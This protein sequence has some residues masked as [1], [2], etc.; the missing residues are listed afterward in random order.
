M[1][2]DAALRYLPIADAI[3][4]NKIKEPILEVG[5]GTNGISDYYDGYV[6]GVD[7]DFSKTNTCKN[8][9]I[10]HKKGTIFKIPFKKESFLKVVCL[11]TLEHINKENR[12]NALNELLRVTKKDGTLYL[13]FPSGF[14]SQQ[15]ETI[16]NKLFKIRHNKKD[17]PW[18]LEHKMY[19]LPGREEVSNYLK[20]SKVS[21]FKIVNNLNIFIWFL[22]HLFFTVLDEDRRI[23]KIT[24]VFKKPIFLF[25]KFLNIPPF[26]RY[27]FIIKK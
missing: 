14:L 15:F 12:Q 11:D 5:S 22:I 16:I 7:N 8:P 13:G 25:G 1:N 4:K 23:L 17:N 24:S 20:V 18:L 10:I 19:G 21:S 2:I 9:N 6:Y 3:M 26:Y 27:I